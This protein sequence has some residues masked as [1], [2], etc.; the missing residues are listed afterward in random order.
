[1]ADPVGVRTRTDQAILHILGVGS[2]SAFPGVAISPPVHDR[3]VTGAGRVTGCVVERRHPFGWLRGTPL[4]DA[5]GQI[6]CPTDPITLRE[7]G[8]GHPR[9]AGRAAR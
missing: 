5:M 1:M 7:A 9:P 6:S 3:S 2:G 8:S 4:G